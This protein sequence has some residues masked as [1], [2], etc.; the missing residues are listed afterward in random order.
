MDIIMSYI[1]AALCV[2][3]LGTAFVTSKKEPYWKAFFY[4]LTFWNAL[5]MFHYM[6]P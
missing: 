1:S 2:W 5:S 3:T 6:K 4:V